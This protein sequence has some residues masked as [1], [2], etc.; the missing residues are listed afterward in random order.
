MGMVAQRWGFEF[1]SPVVVN[2][3]I[4]QNVPSRN[5]CPRGRL[6]KI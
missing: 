3:E 4:A 6:L 5:A 1:W 2:P